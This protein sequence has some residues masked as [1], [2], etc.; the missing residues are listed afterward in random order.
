[1][2]RHALQHGHLKREWQLDRLLHV[3]AEELAKGEIAPLVV[4][5]E[6][7]Y[8]KHIDEAVNL[9]VFGQ[10]RRRDDVVAREGLQDRGNVRAS[11]NHNDYLARDGN[12]RDVGVVKQVHR[13]V[14]WE[15]SRAELPDE[16]FDSNK[17]KS[18]SDIDMVEAG[19]HMTLY[20][21]RGCWLQR[22]SI[23]VAGASREALFLR[24]GALL[25]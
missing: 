13:I 2:T 22:C 9:A 24:P 14:R 6:C 20:A 7:H 3:R 8:V 15:Q 5:E 23:T 12:G 17:K 10:N 11:S 18:T 21:I 25:P 4:L 16:H 1:M 19:S